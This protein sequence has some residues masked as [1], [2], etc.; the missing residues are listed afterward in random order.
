MD[1]SVVE[2]TLSEVEVGSVARTTRSKASGKA[3]STVNTKKRTRN[4]LS[5]SSDEEEIVPPKKV[6]KS[7]SSAT[8][9][10]KKASGKKVTAAKKVPSE[11]DSESDSS[12][13][14]EDE[15]TS[16]APK[17][18]P[19]AKRATGKK[20]SGGKKASTAMDADSEGSEESAEAASKPKKSGKKVTAAKVTKAAAA[21]E[22]SGDED[23]GADGEEMVAVATDFS[24]P[25]LAP[26]ELKIV[27]WNVAS[28]NNVLKKGFSQYLKDE[29][30]DIVCVQ[31]SKVKSSPETFSSA[32]GYYTTFFGCK[33]RP[34]LHGTGILSKTKP[35]SISCELDDNEGRCIVAEFETFYIINTYV[36]NSGRKLERLPYRLDWDKK[37]QALFLS[38]QK[39][40]PVIW[41]GDL[42][43][44]QHPIDLANPSGNKRT[45]GFTE[46]ERASFTKFCDDNGLIDTYRTRHPD[47]KDCYSFWSHMRQ[48]RSKN[49]GWRLD[50]F[51]VSPSL[52][53]SISH[54]YIR[55]HVL[56]SDHC[57]IVIHLK[58]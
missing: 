49:I 28:Y 51:I 14:S 52:D 33:D 27:S 22:E 18:A 37:L 53:A 45:A 56:G 41:C 30:P 50:Y 23:G 36:P 35:L 47:E 3:T 8:V 20:A 17:P 46:Q 40:K 16:G 42:N 10:S 21:E 12:F 2:T 7:A 9:S 34:G 6:S 15:N 19:P 57:P 38:L 31:E 43:V 29:N 5:D 24:Q 44:A 1:E 13:A 39:K 54:S 58:P 4:D 55:K 25:A 48:A 32:L 26:G 11:L